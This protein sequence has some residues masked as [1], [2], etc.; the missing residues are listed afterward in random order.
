MDLVLVA[1][2]VTGLGVGFYFGMIHEEATL[3]TGLLLNPSSDDSA[4]SMSAPKQGGPRSD[5]TGQ[6]G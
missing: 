2:S 6:T 5:Q 3:R 4:T 1:I